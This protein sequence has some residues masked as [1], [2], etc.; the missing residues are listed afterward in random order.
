MGKEEK[1]PEGVGVRV[2]LGVGVVMG[3]GALYNHINSPHRWYGS[4]KI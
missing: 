4:V 2:E 1:G 3:V